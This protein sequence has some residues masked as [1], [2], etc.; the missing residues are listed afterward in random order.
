VAGRI[1]GT[2]LHGPCLARNPQVADQLLSWV[3]NREL[4][5][6]VEDDVAALRAERIDYVARN[7]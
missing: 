2:Y 1:L 7:S 6:I 4:A 3:T 5:Q